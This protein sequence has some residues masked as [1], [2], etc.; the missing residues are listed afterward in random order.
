MLTTM[1]SSSANA[2]SKL[3]GASLLSLLFPAAGL[4][5][6][7]HRIDH[8]LERASVPAAARNVN[9]PGSRRPGVVIPP[10]GRVDRLRR[11]G[12]NVL[13]FVKT[14]GAPRC[15]RE[16]RSDGGTLAQEAL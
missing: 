9:S 2:A 12:E 3:C 15:R 4:A 7:I 6:D 8:V 14:P 13:F 10:T 11:F 16:P 5:I 1:R